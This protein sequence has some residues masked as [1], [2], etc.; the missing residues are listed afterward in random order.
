MAL[1]G[2]GHRVLCHDQSFVSDGARAAFASEHKSACALAGQTPEAIYN[3]VVE[4]WN[5]PDAR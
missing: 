3:E 2:D 4:R 1:L 5:I